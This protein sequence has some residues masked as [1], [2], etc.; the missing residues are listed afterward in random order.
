MLNRPPALHIFYLRTP[1]WLPIASI[2][3]SIAF[4]NS[5][6]VVLT[7]ARHH[8]TVKDLDLLSG[9][10]VKT[11]AELAILL[12]LNTYPLVKIYV[13]SSTKGIEELETINASLAALVDTGIEVCLYPDGYTNMFYY[14]REIKAYIDSQPLLNVGTAVFFEKY[15]DANGLPRSAG[16]KPVIAKS[17]GIDRYCSSDYAT[18]HCN[19]ALDNMHLSAGSRNLL[20]ILRPW[21]SQVFLKGRLAIDNG[22]HVLADLLSRSINELTDFLS[23]G[24]HNILIRPDPRD[25]DFSLKVATLLASRI[26]NTN[27]HLFGENWPDFLTVD[28][29]LY[30]FDTLSPTSS[31]Y[32]YSFDSTATLPFISLRKCTGHFL[33]VQLELAREYGAGKAYDYLSRKVSY[34]HSTLDSIAD[35]ELEICEVAEGLR[36]VSCAQAG[37]A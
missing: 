16:F 3:D 34:L 27:V 20:V 17:S 11:G 24:F 10:Q 36:Y 26:K 21:G 23:F 33:G 2:C 18:Y 19:Q 1:V 8:A 14:A 25:M 9:V 22:D 15:Q 28:P 13:Q 4:D 29:F 6:F 30:N 31:L 12:K 35:R 37:A 32:T 5:T 7:S